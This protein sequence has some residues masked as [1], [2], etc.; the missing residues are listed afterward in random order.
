[1]KLGFIGLGAMGAGIALNL[2]KAGHEVTVILPGGTPAALVI[3]QLLRFAGLI[4]Y[5]QARAW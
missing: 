5:N 2:A 1:M 4:N 3:R